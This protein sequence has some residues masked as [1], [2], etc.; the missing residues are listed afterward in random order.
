MRGLLVKNPLAVDWGYFKYAPSIIR[1]DL[2]S[3][4]RRPVSHPLY[5]FLTKMLIMAT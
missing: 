4:G 3:P 2:P 5:N 1:N